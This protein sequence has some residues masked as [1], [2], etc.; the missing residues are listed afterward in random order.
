M[1]RRGTRTQYDVYLDRREVSVPQLCGLFRS[2]DSAYLDFVWYNC[3]SGV[4]NVLNAARSHKDH[5]ENVTD[6]D[7]EI[8][9]VKKY[10]EIE[11]EKNIDDVEKTDEVVEEKDIDVA[12]GSIEFRKENMQTLIPS[13]TRSPSKVSSSDKIVFE[14]LTANVSPTTVTSSKYS[15]TSKHNKK[16]I[17][18]KMKILPGSITGMCRRRGKFVLIS[19]TNSLLLSSL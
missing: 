12:T 13:P 11:K 7:E 10:K 3:I 18:Y 2:E 1:D 19:K 17:S 6:D 5:L 15:S 16:S 8:E 9:K 14:E 4:P